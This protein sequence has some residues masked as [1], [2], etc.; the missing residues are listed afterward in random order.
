MQC[1]D[2]RTESKD[3]PSVGVCQGCGA[4]VCESHARITSRTVRH[5]TPQGPSAQSEARWVLC[6]VCAEAEALTATALT[7]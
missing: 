7:L 3:T 6:K 5:G 4:G 1:L 2:C